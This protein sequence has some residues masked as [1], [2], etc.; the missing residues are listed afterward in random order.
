MSFGGVKECS[1]ALITPQAV[2]T[3]AHCVTSQDPVLTVQSVLISYHDHDLVDYFDNELTTAVAITVHPGYDFDTLLNDIALVEVD[4]VDHTLEGV[5]FVC[6][7]DPNQSSSA[8][9]NTEAV[10]TGWGATEPDPN[11]S[12]EVLLGG[13]VSIIDHETCANQWEGQENVDEST[14][15]C[16]AGDGV[17]QCYGDRGGPITVLNEQGRV[18]VIGI[19]S[20]GNCGQ[21]GLPSVATRVTTYVTWIESNIGGNQCDL[22]ANI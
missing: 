6:L 14:M 22:L 3:A 1:G 5:G 17:Y 4:S 8:Y 11:S 9:D 19:A 21:N 15:M 10:V 7:P 2:L 13:T 18:E 20:W 16:N 12:S